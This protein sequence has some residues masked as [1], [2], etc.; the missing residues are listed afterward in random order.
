MID[1]LLSLSDTII[2]FFVSFFDVLFTDLWTTL[3]TA[4]N[5]F[6]DFLVSTM[7]FLG[8][9]TFLSNVTMLGFLFSTGLVVAIVVYFFIP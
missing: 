3:T 6:T 8:L 9:E 5:P 1:T 2:S 7:D 4:K